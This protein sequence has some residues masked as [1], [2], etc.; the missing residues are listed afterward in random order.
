MTLFEGTQE[1]W[2]HSLRMGFVLWGVFIATVLVG[3]PAL[4][5]DYAVG[6]GPVSLAG[7]ILLSIGVL[8]L[9]TNVTYRVVATAAGG[10][11]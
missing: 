9:A 4:V 1:R 2:T 6:S 7:Q 3:A 5:T 8:A 10:E 11:A